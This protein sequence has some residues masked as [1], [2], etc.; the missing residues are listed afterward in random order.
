MAETIS[1]SNKLSYEIIVKIFYRTRDANNGNYLS[2]KLKQ[3][4]FSKL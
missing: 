3:T 4:Y 2:P 1:E